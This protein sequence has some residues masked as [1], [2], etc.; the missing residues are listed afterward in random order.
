MLFCP[1]F[2]LQLTLTSKAYALINVA[3]MP[4]AQ[5]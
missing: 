2:E 4:A 3:A 5:I 1:A